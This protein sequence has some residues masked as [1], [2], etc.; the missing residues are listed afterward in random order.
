MS[1]GTVT[2]ERGAMVRAWK[3]SVVL[4]GCMAGLQSARAQQFVVPQ[5][6]AVSNRDR[7]F[8]GLYEFSEAGAV[9][10]RVRDASATWYNPAGLALS[11]RT[12]FNV[13]S[14]AYQ[15]TKLGSDN[16]PAERPPLPTPPRRV[17]TPQGGGATPPPPSFRGRP[18]SSPSPA[19][20]AS[21]SGRRSSSGTGCAWDWGSTTRPT[22]TPRC[23][24][25]ATPARTPG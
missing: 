24:S 1:P 21:P 3:R 8:P 6:L 7:I 9:V 14:A 23:V 20:W 17:I 13:S 11:E 16:A 18:A 12:T 2:D 10:A 15:L 5:T 19:L 25:R 4:L 22:G